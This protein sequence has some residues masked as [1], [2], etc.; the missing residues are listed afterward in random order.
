[1]AWEDWLHYWK[2]LEYCQVIFQ[3]YIA[4]SDQLEYVVH[5]AEWGQVPT[6]DRLINRRPGYIRNHLDT[7]RPA[8]YDDPM[9][10]VNHHL[11]KYARHRQDLLAENL[12]MD[13]ILKIIPTEVFT[14]IQGIK[15]GTLLQDLEYV[16]HTIWYNEDGGL[17]LNNYTPTKFFGCRPVTPLCSSSE[18]EVPGKI[19]GTIQEWMDEVVDLEV[20]LRNL[21]KRL[22]TTGN[23]ITQMYEMDPSRPRPQVDAY[24][25]YRNNRIG[26]LVTVEFRTI[27]EQWTEAWLMGNRARKIVR[28]KIMETWHDVH[29]YRHA[30]DN[31]LLDDDQ[32]R[33]AREKMTEILEQRGQLILNTRSISPTRPRRCADMVTME[34][35][36]FSAS[37][38]GKIRDFG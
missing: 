30:S 1:M 27:L 17:F 16:R 15:D 4:D 35:K 29:G 23:T 14:V 8:F 34:F 22:E 5:L 31:L 12:S 10:W 3:A 9:T 7:M 19:G 25:S 6:P 11:Q 33:I 13:F 38:V 36:V 28:W 24:N 2:I 26:R 32:R 18:D 37:M 20:L 21:E